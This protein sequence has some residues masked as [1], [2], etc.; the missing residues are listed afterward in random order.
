MSATG[1]RLDELR[2][3]R[4]KNGTT[5]PKSEQNGEAVT[6]T[7]NGSVD[8]N[9][10]KMKMAT[11]R[12]R[13]RVISLSD[14]SGED[15]GITS[16]NPSK[17]PNTVQNV[18]PVKL[19]IAER[20]QR[21][22]ELKAQFKSVDAMLLQNELLRVDWDVA[23]A[24]AAMNQKKLNQNNAVQNGHHYSHTSH[25]SNSSTTSHHKVTWLLSVKTNN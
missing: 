22:I 25:A 14:S 10:S 3:Y 20:E 17:I 21:L 9:T 23:K 5:T 2:K 24:V 8:D 6:A 15:D 13:I 1:S 16:R 7:A 18:S 19:T 12:K 11:G 4:F